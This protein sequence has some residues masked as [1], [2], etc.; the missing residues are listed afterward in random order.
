M[1]TTY[2]LIKGETL[3]SS[4]AS[5]TFTAIPST[6]TDLVLR[7]SARD[8]SNT[9]N[10][11]SNA[12]MQIN[13]ITTNYSETYLQGTSTTATTSAL[14]ST[15]YWWLYN[16]YPS[17]L[18]TSNTFSNNETYLPSYAGAANKVGSHSAVQENNLATFESA[19]I[20]VFATL[21][22]NTAAISS[23]AILAATSFAAGSSFYLYGI[24]NS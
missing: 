12:R 3:T 10:Y 22:S 4:A 16:S 5:Y 13:S 24:K 15:N 9:G 1:G 14:T 7:W 19:N 11:F 2:E 8:T 23:V 20:L 6:W 18:S 21:L 17:S